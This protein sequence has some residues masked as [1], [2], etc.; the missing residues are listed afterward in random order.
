MLLCSIRQ[1]L[2]RCA[3]GGR[4]DRLSWWQHVS[5]WLVAFAVVSVPAVWL[6]VMRQDEVVESWS[7]ATG[8]C[9]L[10]ESKIAYSMPPPVNYA[11]PG[12]CTC[13]ATSLDDEA[14][15]EGDVTSGV[16]RGRS[17]LDS[18][19]S[20]CAWFRYWGAENVS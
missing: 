4:P 9:P 10:V 1:W 6:P 16:S 14:L 19:V 7:T 20:V 5:M 2:W 13:G 17:A 12:E 8:S 3:F 15:V 11:T 18:D